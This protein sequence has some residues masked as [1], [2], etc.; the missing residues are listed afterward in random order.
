MIEYPDIQLC[1]SRYKQL[2]EAEEQLFAR[3]RQI[4]TRLSQISEEKKVVNALIDMQADWQ[5]VGQL[6]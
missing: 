6:K 3:Q 1:R 2:I 5:V 4:N